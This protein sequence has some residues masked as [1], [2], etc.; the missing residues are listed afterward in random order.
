LNVRVL[1]RKALLDLILLEET[2][3]GPFVEWRVLH[4]LFIVILQERLLSLVD[5]CCFSRVQVRIK[6]RITDLIEQFLLLFVKFIGIN[7]IGSI[8]PANQ[9]SFIVQKLVSVTRPDF[10]LVVLCPRLLLL[11]NLLEDVMAFVDELEARYRLVDR[12][13][14]FDFSISHRVGLDEATHLTEENEWSNHQSEED[15]SENP[16]QDPVVDDDFSSE[17]LLSDVVFVVPFGH[18]KLN[19]ITEE[20][21]V[22]E[23]VQS[24]LA[25]VEVEQ[26]ADF[27]SE[28]DRHVRRCQLRTRHVALQQANAACGSRQREAPA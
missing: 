5:H 4:I 11:S 12:E 9:F 17:D 14:N 23:V 7:F 27:D 13:A 26:A 21:E 19:V 20:L 8:S 28:W 2:S 6:G 18:V 16:A 15:E 22:L 1:W 24:S 25:E 10:N 3:L